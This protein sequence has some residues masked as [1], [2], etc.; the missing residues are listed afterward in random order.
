MKRCFRIIIATAVLTLLLAA[1]AFAAGNPGYGP[2]YH[3]GPTDH[4]GG[5][6]G[7]GK[8]CHPPNCI[9]VEV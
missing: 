5:G 4:P 1:S 8:D 6:P 3:P 9:I 2:E 7:Y